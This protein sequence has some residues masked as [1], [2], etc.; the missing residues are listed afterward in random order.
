MTD[1]YYFETTEIKRGTDHPGRMRAQLAKR[2]LQ[3]ESRIQREIE[4][5]RRAAAQIRAMIAKLDRAVSSLEDSINADLERA[6]VRDPSHYAY[7]ISVR[8]MTARRENLK[9]TIAILLERLAKVDPATNDSSLAS[10]PHVEPLMER[11]E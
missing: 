8:T 10:L 11:N 4:D 1:Q 3:D 7:P 5:N 6:Y 2:R 9:A